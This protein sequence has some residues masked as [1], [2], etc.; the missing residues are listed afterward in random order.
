M[1]G[2]VRAQINSCSPRQLVFERLGL[3]AGTASRGG[4]APLWGYLDRVPPSFLS[5]I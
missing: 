1:A 2:I 4:D 3:V 5:K